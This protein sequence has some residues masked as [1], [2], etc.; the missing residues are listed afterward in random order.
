M[1]TTYIALVLV[2]AY[3]NGERVEIQPGEALPE[4]LHQH[5]IDELLRLRSIE[6]EAAAAAAK[7]EAAKEGKAALAEFEA[8]RGA[9]KAA[10]ESITVPDGGT[11]EQDTTGGTGAAGGDGVADLKVAAAPKRQAAAAKNKGV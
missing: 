8:A 9:V 10:A 11:G 6:D 1:K 3:I 2:I 7:K 5:D 4:G